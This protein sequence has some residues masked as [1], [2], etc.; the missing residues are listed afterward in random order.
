ME[1]RHSNAFKR[2]VIVQKWHDFAKGECLDIFQRL[3]WNLAR[4]WVIFYYIQNFQKWSVFT[5]LSFWFLVLFK[6]VC[7]AV[8]AI[9]TKTFRQLGFPCKAPIWNGK[10]HSNDFL[11]QRVAI[12][13]RLAIFL[14]NTSSC[15]VHKKKETR[16]ICRGIL[17]R[18]KADGLDLCEALS[19]MK[20][21]TSCDST[22]IFA[23]KG[24]KAD[25]RFCK[26]DIVEWKGMGV[27][28]ES[29]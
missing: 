9:A 26:I 25:F 15:L 13:H 19:R 16:I 22:S 17:V 3:Y 12:L 20:V 5:S 27:P 24:S 10:K 7:G 11:G 21:F 2:H 8:G 14:E 29:E 1:Q 6:F 23:V 18:D 28:L 4:K